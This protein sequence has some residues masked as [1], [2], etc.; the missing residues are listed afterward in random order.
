M[1]FQLSLL[2]VP[3]LAVLTLVGSPAVLPGSQAQAACHPQTFHDERQ[4]GGVCC[5]PD[6]FHSGA[7]SGAATKAKA[8]IEAVR[9]WEDFV[10][11]EYGNSYDHWS[12]ARSKSV[13]CSTSNGWSCTVEARACHRAG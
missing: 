7:S 2:A 1:R 11:F 6:H 4:E 8:T 9:A 3:A 10:Y 13:S 5:F 12:M